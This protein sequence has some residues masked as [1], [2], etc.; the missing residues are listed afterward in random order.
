MKTTTNTWTMV[1]FIRDNEDSNT[2]HITKARSSTLQGHTS[3]RTLRLCLLVIV[4]MARQLSRNFRKKIMPSTLLMATNRMM[5]M[6]RRR[7]S[8]N[9]LPRR[10]LRKRRIEMMMVNTA[11]VLPTASVL[12]IRIARTQTSLVSRTA[13][14]TMEKRGSCPIA[15]RGVHI[16]MLL[17]GRPVRVQ[18]RAVPVLPCHPLRLL[19]HCH[20]Y[21]SGRRWHRPRTQME[22]RT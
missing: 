13:A 21:M 22:V 15:V 4:V 17:L 14:T 9:S 12:E 11:L 20:L 19:R 10:P 3:I 6:R 7:R 8:T 2:V 1:G 16:L 5:M 18:A